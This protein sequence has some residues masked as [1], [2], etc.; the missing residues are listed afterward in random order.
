MDVKDIKV[1]LPDTMN[2]LPSNIIQT[3]LTLLP[4]RDAFRTSIL[5]RNWRHHCV[6]IPKLQFDD[7]MFKGSNCNN[8]SV[9]CKLTHV[10]YP[11]LLLHRGPILDFSLCISELSSC[12]QIDQIISYLS[13]K[14][15]V[16]QFTLCFRVGD[17]HKLPSSFFMLQQLTCLKLQNCAFQPPSTFCGFSRL[18]SLYFHNVSI[19]C[20]VLLRFIVNCPL[21]TSFTL[22]GDEKH[23]LGCWNSGFVELF[24][25]LPLIEY[26]YMSSYPV[27]CFAT[28]DMPQKLPT[29]LDRLRVLNLSR[30]CFAR[31]VQLRSALLLV[32]SS[33]NIQ[34]I[35][36]K[37]YYNQKEAVSQTAMN[38]LD[39]QD[40][41]N[42]NLD[43]LRELEITNMSSVK[44][45]LDFV[46]LILAKSPMLQK[47]GI[48]LDNQVAVASEVKMLRDLLQFQRAST[49]AEIVFTRP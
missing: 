7:E 16:K 18:T 15:T 33:P 35:I 1:Y 6:N 19:T 29:L 41:S 14:S 36:M 44:P 34:K 5:S 4:M 47:V 28:G 32:T 45:E 30:L 12:Y 24:E 46:K 39:L 31:E 48:V 22:I 23:L 2:I 26:L 25:C 40:Y 37:M 8:L 13:K 27:Q 9:T 43:H 17:N 38:L 3:M 20:K 49:K 11:I 42:V 10:I 21:L